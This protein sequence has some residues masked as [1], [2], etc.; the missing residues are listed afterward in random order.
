MLQ[1]RFASAHQI[2]AETVGL[3]HQAQDQIA[4]LQRGSVRAPLL[5]LGGETAQHCLHIVHG[6]GGRLVHRQFLKSVLVTGGHI[7]VAGPRVAGSTR[8]PLGRSI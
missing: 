1:S 7:L 2:D 4:Q 5:P 3:L 8:V 6:D